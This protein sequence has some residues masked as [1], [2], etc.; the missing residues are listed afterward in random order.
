MTQSVIQDSTR[1]VIQLL[2]DGKYEEIEELT[3]GIRLTATD[4][5]NAIEE[6]GCHLMHPPVEEYATLDIIEVQA[7]P[8]PTFAVCMDLWTREEG[9]SDLSMELTMIEE[10]NGVRIELDDIHVL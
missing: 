10:D 2:V 7:A 8:V 4:I 5:R 3:Q 6:Y 1:K 9:R